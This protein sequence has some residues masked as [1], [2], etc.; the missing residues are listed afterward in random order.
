[1]ADKRGVKQIL[2]NLLSN[3]VKFSHAGG[4]VR[5]AAHA[6]GDIMAIMVRDEGVGIPESELPRLGRAFEQVGDDAM[7]ARGGTGLG[8]ALVR[9]L[10]AEHGGTT[11]IISKENVGTEVTVEL[12]LRPSARVAA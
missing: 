5:V 9:A 6:S 2:L 11:R 7:L 3:A 8:L 1:M 4:H 12:P 10:A